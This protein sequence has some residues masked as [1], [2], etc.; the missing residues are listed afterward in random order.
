MNRDIAETLGKYSQN[1]HHLVQLYADI[2]YYRDPNYY[3][4]FTI[5]G[6][7]RTYIC[8]NNRLLRSIIY[9]NH[10]ISCNNSIHIQYTNSDILTITQDYFHIVIV[11]DMT[12]YWIF[13]PNKV[14]LNYYKAGEYADD[15]ELIAYYGLVI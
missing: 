13:C 6:K 10:N 1:P 12:Y 15:D 11:F 14:P 3:Y 2:G 4:I 8:R 9:H 5:K 7:S